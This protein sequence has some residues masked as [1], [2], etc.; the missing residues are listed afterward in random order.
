MKPSLQPGL[1]SRLEYTVPAERTV[2]HLL[3][4]SPDFLQMPE[5]LATGYLVGIVEWACVRCIADHLEGG[6]A[7][8]GIHVDLSHDAP[9]P[10]GSTVVVEVELTA[11]D[12][13]LLTFAVGARD[14]AAPIATGTHRRAVIS[15]E[16]FADRLRARAGEVG[17]HAERAARAQANT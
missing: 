10:P 16:R 8:L 14:D 12:G 11:V 3:P 7:T 5:V 17:T 1:T 6:E 13:R 9:T 4:E 15:K 2:P